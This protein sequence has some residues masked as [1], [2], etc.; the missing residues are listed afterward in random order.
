[1]GT[2]RMFSNLRLYFI[3]VS[4]REIVGKSLGVA[5]LPTAPKGG[6]RETNGNASLKQNC[7]G[8]EGFSPRTLTPKA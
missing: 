5:G 2:Q 8:V 4:E 3:S 1:M 7:K 6:R